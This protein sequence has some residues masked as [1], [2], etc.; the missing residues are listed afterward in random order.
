MD[1]TD[2]KLNIIPSCYTNLNCQYC[3]IDKFL[4][5]VPNVMN[6]R[7]LVTIFDHFKSRGITDVSF[8][9]GEP[10]LNAWRLIEIL[11]LAKSYF[12]TF[13]LL[14]NALLLE[15]A[16]LDHLLDLGLTEI[17]INLLSLNKAEYNSM[18]GLIRSYDL[19]TD[20][21]KYANANDML[22]V[23]YVPIFGALNLSVLDDFD[24]FMT[25]TN[26]TNITFLTTEPNQ[27]S[28]MDFYKNISAAGRLVRDEDHLEVFNTS[29][30]NIGFLDIISYV[31]EEGRYYLYPDL[32]IR[33]SLSI[34]DSV[35]EIPA[36]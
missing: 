8:I 20:V 19:P 13:S 16:L 17:K 3:Y 36:V 4:P 31:Q 35:Y 5:S 1:L 22:T 24:A 29:K 2:K 28:S 18:A 7:R 25:A 14:T 30:Y 10:L 33:T 6:K 12:S 32:E 9:G 26:S 11:K 27:F 34:L 23:L 15:E 21:I